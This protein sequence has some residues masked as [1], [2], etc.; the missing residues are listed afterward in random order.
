MD[1]LA[2]E[3][4][5]RPRKSSGSCQ[6]AMIRRCPNGETPSRVSRMTTF[7]YMNVGGTWGTE[8]SKYPEE[9]KSI[10]MPLVA[11]SESGLV[12]T[13]FYAQALNVGL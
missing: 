10:E 5:A 12:Q 7:S 4:R 8:I 13:M 9:K 11:T 6:E 2:E 1:V 3:G